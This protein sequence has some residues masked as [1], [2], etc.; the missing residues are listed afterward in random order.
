MIKYNKFTQNY[1]GGKRT[2]YSANVDGAT[3][4]TDSLKRLKQLIKDHKET[5][6]G[7]FKS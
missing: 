4:H 3:Y 2:I 6:Q 5:I 1:I 7:T